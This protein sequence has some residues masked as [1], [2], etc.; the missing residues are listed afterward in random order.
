MTKGHPRLPR[1]HGLLLPSHKVVWTQVSAQ[2][3]GTWQCCN[4]TLVMDTQTG[5][6]SSK[7]KW[8]LDQA[9]QATAGTHLFW[10]AMLYRMPGVWCGHTLHFSCQDPS[11]QHPLPCYATYRADLQTSGKTQCLCTP[12][13]S[14][15]FWACSIS[16]HHLKIKCVGSS[17]L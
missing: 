17:K 3:T 12:K 5:L 7:N 6:C 1:L 9:A 15:I 2:A 10:A 14:T 8:S 13:W 11:K 16:S 4:E